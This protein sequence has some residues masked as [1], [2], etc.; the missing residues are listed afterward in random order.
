LE[1]LL[2]WEDIPNYDAEILAEIY[3]G[4]TGDRKG[5][6]RAFLNGKKRPDL[7]FLLNPRGAMPIL[8]ASEEIALINFNPN[9]NADGVWYLGHTIPEVQ[10][11]HVNP[12][13]E[14]RLLAPDHYKID[15][16]LGSP[17]IISTEPDLSVT[18]DLSFHALEAGVRMVKLDLMP[19][20][21]VSRVVW[22]GI[23]IPYVQESRSH[24]GSF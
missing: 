4:D 7:R 2:N 13:E 24:D 11:G 17:K 22:N 20:L 21:Q 14:K 12:K 23:D 18:C 16:V 1:T 10:S 8:R 19:D 15:A 3:N 9:S 5:S 6:F